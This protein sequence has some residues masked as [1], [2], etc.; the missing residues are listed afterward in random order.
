MILIDKKR[1]RSILFN[2]L[3]NAFKYTE[4]GFVKLSCTKVDKMSFERDII[5][6]EFKIMDTGI[7]I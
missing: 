5:H 1:L 4:E 7:G 3:T 6:L 2:L